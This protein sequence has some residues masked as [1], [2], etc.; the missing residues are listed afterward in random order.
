MDESHEG[1]ESFLASEGD[2]SEALEF[3]EETFDLM[4]LFVEPPIDWRGNGTAG[5]GLDLGGCAEIIGDEAAQRI[6]IISCVGDDMANTLQ[7]R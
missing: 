6:G 3:V 4:A 7:T 2:P 5:V 1:G